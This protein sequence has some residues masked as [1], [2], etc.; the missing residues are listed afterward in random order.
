V[1]LGA[2]QFPRIP[3]SAK[4][5][6][7][8]REITVTAEVASSSLVVPAIFFQKLMEKMALRVLPQSGG[9]VPSVPIFLPIFPS[10]F[11]G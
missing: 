6:D 11:F 9:N 3:E 1:Q 7:R 4:G 10:L 8:R 2:I 5:G